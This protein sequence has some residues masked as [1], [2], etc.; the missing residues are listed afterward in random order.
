MS[1]QTVTVTMTRD[2][3]AVINR[4]LSRAKAEYDSE[5]MKVG[6][7]EEYRIGMRI[8]GDAVKHFLREIATTK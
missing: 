6:M 7:R 4:V 5:L 1:T 3:W 2:E 8:Y